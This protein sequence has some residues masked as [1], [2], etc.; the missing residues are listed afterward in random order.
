MNTL[1]SIGV[2]LGNG[3]ETQERREDEKE[4]NERR[5][6]KQDER[7]ILRPPSELAKENMLRRKIQMEKKQKAQ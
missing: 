2:G 1:T 4:D 3:A 7:R 6:M 5:T